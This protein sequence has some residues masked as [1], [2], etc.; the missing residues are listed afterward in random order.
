[1]T[2]VLNYS[3][4]TPESIKGI[5]V[6]DADTHLTE[7]A[8][9]WT[10]LAPE[11]YKDQVPRVVSSAGREIYNPHKGRMES[12][13]MWIWVVG[14]NVMGRAG[15][16]S[17]INHQNVKHKGPGFTH[18]PLTEV[19]PA[20]SF[21]E[22]RLDLMD[23]VGIWGQII[24]PNVVGFGG[25]AFKAIEDR[26]LRLLCAQIW[27]DTMIELYENS[28]GRLH[29]MAM[30]PWWDIEAAVKETQRV[31]AQGLKGVNITSDPQ[32]QDL[33]DLSDLHW[34]PLWEVCESLGMPINFHVGASDTGVQWYGDSPWPSFEESKRLAI[35]SAMLY[36]G[37]ARVVANL[38]FSGILERHP[39]LKFVSV[40]SGIG[41]MPFLLEALDYQADEAN[42]RLSMKPSE[43][44]HRQIYSC[45]WFENQTLLRDIDFVG[46]DKVMFETDFPHPTCLYPEPLKQI[47]ATLEK[48]DFA[49]REAVLS[50]NA[51]RLY[52]IDTSRG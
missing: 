21:L 43:Y 45:F 51:A 35:G 49:K 30:I 18:W 48:V 40:E 8:D 31:H 33:P 3:G 5:K 19:S 10:R 11:K 4:R 15:G 36:L 41:W 50:G 14:D 13:D 25:Q 22:P 27:N 34:E 39:N 24:Y 46:W 9:L 2:E 32:H 26:Q 12:A 16:G 47:G 38:I 28:N 20:A 23:E 6:I 42:V 52:N 29:G 37:N 44:F 7:P 17:V 1:M